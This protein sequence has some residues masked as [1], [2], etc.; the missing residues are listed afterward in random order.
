MKRRRIKTLGGI[1]VNVCPKCGSSQIAVVDS[2]PRAGI[3]WRRRKCLEC[4]GKYTTYEVSSDT[5][6]SLMEART[7]MDRAERIIKTIRKEKKN[8]RTFEDSVN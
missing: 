4:D 7:F 6:D 3:V 5:Y 2:R 1:G 8:G